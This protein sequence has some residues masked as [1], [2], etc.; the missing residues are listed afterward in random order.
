MKVSLVCCLLALRAIARDLWGEVEV[1]CNSFT[2]QLT[3]GSS[4]GDRAQ[5]AALQSMHPDVDLTD[6]L[7]MQTR[8]V[9]AGFDRTLLCVSQ[10]ML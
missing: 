10:R 3:S 2:V 8:L 1:L 6:A 5:E 4:V 9:S 7:Q